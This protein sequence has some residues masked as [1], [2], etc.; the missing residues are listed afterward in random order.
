MKEYGGIG[1]WIS[2]VWVSDPF[3]FDT[4]PDPAFLAEFDPDP[5]RIRIRIQSGS[6]VFMTKN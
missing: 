1:P 4:D 6:R 3:S 5:F 2:S